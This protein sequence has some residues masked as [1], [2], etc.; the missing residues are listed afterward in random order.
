MGVELEEDPVYNSGSP[1]A[2]CQRGEYH[3]N[4]HRRPGAK[5]SVL[6]FLGAVVMITMLGLMPGLR[7]DFMVDGKPEKLSMVFRSR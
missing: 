2:N 3:R 5:W 4:A 1:V 7:P 6:L